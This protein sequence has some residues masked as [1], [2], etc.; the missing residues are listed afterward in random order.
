MRPLLPPNATLEIVDFSRNALPPGELRF[1]ASDLARP[2]AN[3]PVG[4]RAVARPRHLRTSSSV[5]V[6]AKVR[7]LAKE[8]WVE[9]ARA[10]SRG[11]GDRSG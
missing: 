4:S 1:A 10:D 9:A 7:V 5:L 2:P 11:A 3:R 6:W 8:T